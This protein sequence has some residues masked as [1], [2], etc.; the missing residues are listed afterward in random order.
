[1][2]NELWPLN[3]SIVEHTRSGDRYSQWVM[4]TLIMSIRKNTDFIYQSCLSHDTYIMEKVKWKTT[5]AKRVCLLETRSR[6]R[7]FVTDDHKKICVHYITRSMN[8]NKKIAPNS[9][10]TKLREGVVN[11]KT[12]GAGEGRHWGK[13]WVGL[14]I[15]KNMIIKL[16]KYH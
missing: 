5:W 11:M 9:W 12:E 13:P 8:S 4:V 2:S 15:R 7:D 14:R 3:T 6:I 1:M 16:I 10:Y